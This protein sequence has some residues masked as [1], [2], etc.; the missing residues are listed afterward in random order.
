MPTSVGQEQSQQQQQQQQP[1]VA[2]TMPSGYGVGP[3][4]ALPAV[5]NQHQIQIPI[6]QPSPAPSQ[7]SPPAVLPVIVTIQQQPT[8][9]Q[10]PQMQQMQPQ[11]QQVGVNPQANASS[12]TLVNQP[13]QQPAK[14]PA[15]GASTSSRAAPQP[16]NA[17]GVPS[18][19]TVVNIPSGPAAAVKPTGTNGHESVIAPS[20]RR[21]IC[22]IIQTIAS[23][24]SFAMMIGSYNRH[25]IDNPFRGTARVNFLYF[26]SCVSMLAGLFYVLNFFYNKWFRKFYNNVSMAKRLVVIN[27]MIVLL[28]WLI[29]LMVLVT[30][31]QCPPGGYSGWC[32]LYNTALAFG[33]IAA[34]SVGVCFFWNM[35]NFFRA[36]LWKKRQAQTSVL[37]R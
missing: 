2:V 27:D 21:L 24:A 37:P 10:N 28:L 23:F 17:A 22:R 9:A 1:F 18:D 19:A 20:R 12:A 33:F 3:A 15:R 25:D 31:N 30:T 36:K 8:I 34:F 5:A 7:Q 16:L 26:V 35:I 13:N 14:N 4:Q 6:P 29:S 11:M 32:D